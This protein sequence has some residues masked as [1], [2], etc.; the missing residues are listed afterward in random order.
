MDE[1]PLPITH[2]PLPV[3][4]DKSPVVELVFLLQP[5]YIPPYSTIFQQQVEH[6]R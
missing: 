2:Y 4:K 6:G 3:I 1:N 5:V